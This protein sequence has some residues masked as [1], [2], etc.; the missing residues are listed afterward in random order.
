[1]RTAGYA[2]YQAEVLSGGLIA[3]SAWY[4]PGDNHYYL[5]SLTGEISIVPPAQACKTHACSNPMEVIVLGCVTASA[6]AETV[7]QLNTFRGQSAQK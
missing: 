1:M 6:H 7:G 5:S 3:L 4:T 2:T